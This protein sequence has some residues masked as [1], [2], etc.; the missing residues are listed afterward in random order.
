MKNHYAHNNIATSV[1]TEQCSN[2]NTD[3]TVDA[4]FCYVCG[5]R[6]DDIIENIG[7]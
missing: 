1:I 3:K 4:C 7:N 2:S 5:V 6:F